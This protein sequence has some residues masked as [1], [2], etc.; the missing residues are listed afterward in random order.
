MFDTVATPR[1]E[2][3][4]IGD[5]NFES[6]PATK[7][8]SITPRDHHRQNSLFFPPSAQATS[9]LR[10]KRAIQDHTL[11]EPKSPFQIL[12]DGQIVPEAT[13]RPR[14][15]LSPPATSG[16]SKFPKIPL[17]PLNTSTISQQAASVPRSRSRTRPQDSKLTHASR[18]GRDPR[19]QS[20]VVVESQR[21][22]PLDRASFFSEQKATD[23][24]GMDDS[25][26]RSHR[27]L[28][29]S[30]GQRRSSNRQ[31]LLNGES[32]ELVKK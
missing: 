24:I 25:E 23:P 28:R 11:P 12:A 1:Q 7:N 20:E 10:T 29:K 16:A 22:I 8:M 5:F 9:P 27:L 17:L 4:K 31:K 32:F 19:R 3:M 15:L 2:K 21:F 30:V 14:H 13:A 26:R 6:T 18:T